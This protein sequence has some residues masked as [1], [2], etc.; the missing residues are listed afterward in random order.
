MSKLNLNA[1]KAVS[2]KALDLLYKR[3]Q[4][5]QGVDKLIPDGTDASAT[6]FIKSTV[7]GEV[8]EAEFEIP[9]KKGH[10]QSVSVSESPT[11]AVLIAHLCDRLPDA[12]ANR[13]ICEISERFIA[14]GDDAFPSRPETLEMVKESLANS[15]RETKK[16]DRSGAIPTPEIKVVKRRAKRTRKLA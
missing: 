13:F 3:F 10:S 4:K 6:V 15:K 8:F 16:V 9:V 5:D 14:D 2:Y 11:A 1:L 12:E 7:E